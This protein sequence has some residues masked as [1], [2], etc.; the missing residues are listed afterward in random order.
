LASV[1]YSAYSLCFPEVKLE[2]AFLNSEFD[3]KKSDKSDGIK[4]SLFKSGLIS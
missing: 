3:S 4:I 1:I 2:K